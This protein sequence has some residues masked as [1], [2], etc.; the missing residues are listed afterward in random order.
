MALEA[1][2]GKQANKPEKSY[3]LS[4]GQEAKFS[5]RFSI[6]KEKLFV[7]KENKFL[8]QKADGVLEVQNHIQYAFV[9]GMTLGLETIPERA[10]AIDDDFYDQ[11]PSR[12]RYDEYGQPL[13]EAETKSQIARERW[14]W[15]YTKIVQV[16]ISV[17]TI[18]VIH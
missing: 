8:M 14:I 15:A 5:I 16:R 10:S 3:N 9:S 2:N 7:G 6:P 13:S 4:L 17:A 12:V 11:E 1:A 18:G